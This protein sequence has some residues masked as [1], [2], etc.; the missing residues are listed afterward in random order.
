MLLWAPVPGAWR[1]VLAVGVLV[2]LLQALLGSFLMIYKGSQPLAPVGTRQLLIAVCLSVV[3]S[4]TIAW[5]IVLFVRSVFSVPRSFLL[6]ALP[7]ALLGSLAG[8]YL[9]GAPP[10]PDSEAS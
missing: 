2:V 7:V 10:P 5:L 1:G 9:Y 8:R 6:V 4:G 3:S